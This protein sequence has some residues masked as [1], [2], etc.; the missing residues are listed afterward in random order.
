MR[1]QME[2]GDGLPERPDAETQPMSNDVIEV[3]EN[4]EPLVNQVLELTELYKLTD[5]LYRARSLDDALDAAMDAIVSGLRCSRAS[6]L[7]FDHDGVMRFIAWRG[8]SDGYRKVFDGH[9]PWQAGAD[10]PPPIFVG[11]INATDEPD[12][13]KDAIRSEGIHAL[14]FIPL[15]SQGKVIGKFMAYH[16]L[17]H[18][19]TANEK[20]LAVTIARQLG[21]SIERA[22]M[23]EA[24][25]ATVRELRDSEDRFRQMSEDAPVMIWMSDQNGACLHLNRMQREFWKVSDGDVSNFDWRTTM[26]P[27]DM[28][29][30]VETMIGALTRRESITVIGQY[31]NATGEF[32][33]L[34]TEARP[35]FSCSGEFLGMIGVNIDITERLA[36]EK[37]LR[38]SQERFRLVVEASPSGMIMADGDGQI[39]M[40]N[41]NAERLFGYTRPE[42][43]GQRIDMLVPSLKRENSSDSR[44]AF[45]AQ[46][47]PVSLG[48]SFLALRKDG[49]EVPVE[50]GV[51]PIQTSEGLRVIAAIADIS[52]R[53]RAEAQRELLLAELNHRVKN[54]L[55]VVQSLAY[56]TF[57]KTDTIARKAFEGRLMALA[58]AHNLLTHSN[59]ENASLHKVAA[60]SLQ[61]RDEIQSRISIAGPAILLSPRAALSI[62]LALHEL[63]TNALKYGALSNEAG[64]ITF[65]WRNDHAGSLQLEWREA[66]GPEV[67]APAQK[68]FGSQLLEQTLALDLDG[69]VN[70]HY[71][72]EGLR[73]IITM[74]L[75]ER[76]GNACLG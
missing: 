68:G 44:M 49:A 1:A 20:A 67:T 3:P 22:R 13:V 73:C 61:L 75:S 35:R 7:L 2:T 26:L 34:Q 60:D 42:L 25:Q 43:I 64:T 12:W 63:F 74:P 41:A 48:T 14:A 24:R 32:R 58:T 5:R 62:T 11:D 46:P 18:V 38:D 54:T 71:D 15:T 70:M 52:E 69:A 21:F 9:T 56:R 8:L 23:E 16:E 65:H 39:L 10:E 29:R 36:A 40:V 30:I 76:G 4:T 59:W 28:P 51:N 33:V 53:K 47:E 27:D 37:A 72:P 31:R 19:F 55:A 57:R 6:I 17:P 45:K 66:A 50:I